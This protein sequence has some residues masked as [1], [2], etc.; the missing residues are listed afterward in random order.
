MYVQGSRKNKAREGVL[1]RELLGRLLVVNTGPEIVSLHP[2]T[3]Q[4]KRSVPSKLP[5]MV[6]EPHSRAE[7]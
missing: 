4:Q 5:T 2:S 7:G 6:A 3:Y 1:T